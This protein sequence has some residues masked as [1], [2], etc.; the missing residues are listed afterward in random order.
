MHSVTWNIREKWQFEKDTEF[1]L[2]CLGFIYLFVLFVTV[3]LSRHEPR[4]SR[5]TLGE[6]GASEKG[7]YLKK[8]KLI[9]SGNRVF[10]NIL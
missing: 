1:D 2:E 10:F 6:Y 7:F 8:K 9:H 3:G 5:Q 4:T